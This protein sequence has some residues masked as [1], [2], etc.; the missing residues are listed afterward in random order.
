MRLELVNEE[1]LQAA[2]AALDRL[3]RLV[4]RA[5]GQPRAEGGAAKRQGL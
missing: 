5:R 4:Q 2:R 3:K 1:V